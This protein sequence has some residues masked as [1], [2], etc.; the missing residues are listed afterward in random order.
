MRLW[1][2]KLIPYLPQKQLV[3]QWRECIAIK[4]MWEKGK[5]VNQPLVGYVTKY[6]KKYFFNYVQTLVEELERRKINFQQK[7]YLDFINFCDV[8]NNRTNDLKCLTYNEQDQ[9]YLVIC[10]YNLKEKHLR[11]MISDIEWLN[12][13]SRYLHEICIM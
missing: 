7:Y 6:N 8:Y 4:G 12:I 3:S 9:D 11:G 10:Y 5:L 13:E 2:Y 1:H